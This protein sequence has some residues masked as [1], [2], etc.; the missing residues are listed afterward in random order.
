M[1]IYFCFIDLLKNKIKSTYSAAILKKLVLILQCIN[2]KSSLPTD[3]TR[4]F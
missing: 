3:F 1:Y 2:Y 4:T